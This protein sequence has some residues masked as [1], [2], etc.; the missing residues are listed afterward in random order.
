M[1][2]IL[3]V[4][5]LMLSLCACPE[6]EEQYL[7]RV[8][9]DS[10]RIIEVY[11]STD[12]PDTVLHHDGYFY[13]DRTI[14]PQSYIDINLNEWYENVFDLCSTAQFFIYSVRLT[15]DYFVPKTDSLLARYELTR[16]DLERNGRIIT[17]P[18]K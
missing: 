10:N 1:N 7:V 6:S 18:A 14:Y 13:N 17:Y 12:Y 11:V 15:S 2:R 9:N 16:N 4:I 8:K 3:T 5:A